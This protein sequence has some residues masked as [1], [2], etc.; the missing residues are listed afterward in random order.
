[1]RRGLQRSSRGSPVDQE[2][3][4]RGRGCHKP[5]D[6]HHH[7]G[8]GPGCCGLYPGDDSPPGIRG[9]A[10]HGRSTQQDSESKAR[11]RP[12]TLES[13]NRC[14]RRNRSEDRTASCEIGRYSLGG[15]VKR[16]QPIST[17]CPKCP[18][19][20]RKSTRLNSSH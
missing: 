13:V 11:D 9:T 16:L 6:A 3:Q 10:F 4:G 15:R 20:D 17:S 18:V 7:V 1:T 5:R 14:R 2:A 12:A 19:L 8:G